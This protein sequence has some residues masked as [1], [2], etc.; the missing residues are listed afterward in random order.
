MVKNTG[1]LFDVS[2]NAEEIK[3]NLQSLLAIHTKAIDILNAA[4]G[5]N[6]SEISKTT[7]VAYSTTSSI[8]TRAKS[9]GYVDKSK[10][11]W[12]KNKV[13]KGFDLYKAANVTFKPIIES[14]TEMKKAQRVNNP[15]KPLSYY[16]EGTEMMEGYRAIFCL[17]NTIRQIL[18]SIFKKE[19]EWFAKR[20]DDSIKRDIEKAKNEPYYAHKKRKDDLDYT[21]LGHLF[22]IIISNK[23]WKDI[24]PKLNETDKNSFSATFKKVLS[25]RNAIMHCIPLSKTDQKL[26]DARVRE[27]ALMFKL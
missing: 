11:L 5:R 15:F 20:I 22:Q 8:L 4:K 14:K 6:L 17:E 19:K 25:S 24:L 13:I 21:T 1:R 12:T 3:S 16:K 10:G 27:I 9:F 18:R 23:N 26:I 2:A 7:G